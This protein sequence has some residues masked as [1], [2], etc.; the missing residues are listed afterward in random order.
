MKEIEAIKMRYWI[1]DLKAHGFTDSSI[2]RYVGDISDRAV[3]EFANNKRTM[4]YHTILSILMLIVCLILLGIF[5][6]LAVKL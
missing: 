3:R 6:L 2:S 5:I 1:N 4:W